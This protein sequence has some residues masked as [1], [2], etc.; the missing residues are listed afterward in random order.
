ALDICSEYFLKFGGHHAA[1]GLSMEKDK[2][3][4]FKIKFE[5]VVAE[6]IKEHQ[7]E[8]SILIDSEIQI[9]DV[10]REFINFHRKLAP[11]GPH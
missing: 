1:A 6:K 8:P 7:K 2:F 4:A 5:K 3:D 9:D 11:F 10:N